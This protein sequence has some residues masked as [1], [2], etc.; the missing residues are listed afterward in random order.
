MTAVPKASRWI[1]PEEYLEGEKVAE[2]R[3]EYLAGEVFAMAGASKTHHD[4]AFNI[5]AWLRSA[6]RGKPCRTYME[7]VKVRINPNRET[8]FYYPDVFVGCD[9]LDLHEYFSD[10]PIAIF[11]ILSP[12]TAR[13]DQRE[14]RFAYQTIEAL[15]TYVLV[16]QHK[17]EICLWQRAGD[18]WEP[19]VLNAR[20]DAVPLPG[21]NLALP[22]SE[23]YA[24]I[25]FVSAA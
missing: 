10:Y 25:T 2:I 5:A 7:G 11:E 4:I 15:Q 6:L 18:D 24:G 21:L 8:L 3:H 20:E 1:S 17:V 14:K 13:Y 16:D 9:P 22:V 23:I 12:E 19:L